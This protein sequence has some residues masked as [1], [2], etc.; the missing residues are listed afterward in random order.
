MLFRMQKILVPVGGSP[1]DEAVLR[2]VL[3]ESL[4][5]GPLELHLLNVQ[6]PF[7]WHVARFIPRR[8]RASFYQEQAR[9]AL[10][11]CRQRLDRAGLAY[12]VHTA[13]GDSA[14][15]ITDLADRL[16]CD[17]ILMGTARKD[18]L[19]RLVEDCVVN[20]VLER[21]TVPVEVIA[22]TAVSKWE[23]YGIPAAVGALLAAALVD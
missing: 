18:S 7:H 17:R 11:P 10:A 1:N 21:T 16:R 19:V 12:T 3:R 5:A 22:G 14:A 9:A 2:H 8:E 13:V 6:T 15:C 4:R 20:R 23:R